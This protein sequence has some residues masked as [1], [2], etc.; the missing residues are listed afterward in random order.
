MKKLF[1]AG[2]LGLALFEILNVWFIMPMPGSQ[3]INSIDLAYFL[4]SWR[5]VF[6][7]I[8]LLMAAA[9]SREVIRGQRKWLPALVL[10]FTAGI[11][12]LFNF[13]MTAEKMFR[14]PQS[15][16][17]KSRAENE[18][19]GSRIILGITQGEEAK[20]YPI[21]YLAYHHQVRDSIGG[22]SV[23]VTYCSVCRTGRVFEPVVNGKNEQ[24]RLVGMD[25]FNAMFEDA[26]TKSWWRQVN[27]EAIAGKLKGQE[28]PE[29][30][31]WQMTLD[32]WFALHPHSKVLQ[33]D[34]AFMDIYDPEAN[35]EKGKNQ[36]SLTRTDSLAWKMKSW[37]VGIEVGGASKAYDWNNLKEK[38]IIH[39]SVGNTPL[40][41]ALAADENSFAVFERSPN[42]VFT[43]DANDHLLADSA[44]YDF[45]GRELNSAMPPLQ[46]VSAS[47][48]YWHSW[49][50]FHPE[51]QKYED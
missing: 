42:Q 16:E 49:L 19:P 25:H 9:G 3:Q 10:I 51:T 50:S 11:C 26:T 33:P 8:F 12:Y 2:L 17:L 43:L 14:Q 34:P 27:G 30:E 32:K 23:I 45:S 22:K 31:S 18:V 36:G 28:L 6:R 37:V 40:V 48:E 4:Y 44:A 21:E 24:F 15:V 35:F 46:P 47:Q 1:F 38:R 5:W 29:M 20:A 41:L 13:K 39:D 7:V